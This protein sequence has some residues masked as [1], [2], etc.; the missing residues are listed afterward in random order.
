MWNA[1]SIV[2]L[3]FEALLLL[4]FVIGICQKR[5]L[6]ETALFIG[7]VFVLSFVLHLVPYF[8]RIFALGEEMNYM[9]KLY[10]CFKS[11][12]AMF[13]GSPSFA[14]VSQFADSMP[15]FSVAYV[16]GIVIALLTTISTT[17]EAFRNSI[18]NHLRLT[19]V[20]KSESCDMVIGNSQKALSYAK[21]KRAVLLLD[22]SITKDAAKA[23]MS[24]GY[25]VLRKGFTKKM[26]CGRQLNETTQ[27]NV[28][29]PDETKSLSVVE[30]FIA[31]KKSGDFKKN[32]RLFVEMDGDKAETI[33]R[34]MIDKNGLEAYVDTFCTAE[35]L[36]R[37]FV[38]NNPVTK[39]LPKGFVENGAVKKSADISV[40]VLGFG[41]LGREIYRQSVLNNQLVCYDGEYKVLPIGYWLC[42]NGIDDDE[43]NINGL[44]EELARL[45]AEKHFSLPEMPFNT[46][47]INK[48]P[49]SRQVLSTIKGQLGRDDSYA[50][51]IVDTDDDCYN[52]EIG[53]RLKAMLYDKDNYHIFV[54][55]EAAYTE[56]DGQVTYFGKQAE[57]FCHDVIVNDSLSD[58]AKKLNEMYYAQYAS[59]EERSRPDFDQYVS[60]K[61]EAEWRGF[62]YFTMYSNIYS[63]MSLR[64]KLN[65]MGLDYHKSGDGVST[66][67]INRRLEYKE[68]YEY[69]EYFE[70]SVRNALIAQEHAR[71]N[72][73]HLMSEYLP[74]CKSGI[75]LKSDDGKKVRFNVKNTAA[76]KHAC[77][78]TY[79][80]LNELSAYLAEKSGK[81]LTASDY[82]Y[83]IYDEMLITSAPEL[84]DLLGYSVKEL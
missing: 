61:A 68:H 73:Y 8:Y 10:E 26:L 25:V 21:E 14:A 29:C 81:G 18:A 42:D 17:L 5:K 24:R 82:D 58:M 52:I 74:L 66:E 1:I 16:L 83:Y 48:C 70:P 80:G 41:R 57:V 12:L 30:E 55:S 39:Y 9:F 34:E 60:E 20:L 22:D 33:R 54:R 53:A 69:S 78:T 59:D 3:I 43:W 7:A 31:Y 63:A 28:I 46:R 77:L 37:S 79:K 11:S 49:A 4:G 84:L 76:K 2:I 64:V 23:L 15:A 45:D 38:E 47:V 65:L 67:E 40:F 32:I 27:Y 50:M 13:V 56:N 71:W 36:A 44:P 72:A 6:N 51:I 62:D 75:T 35:L 19:K